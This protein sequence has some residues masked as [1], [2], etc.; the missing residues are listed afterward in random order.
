M[1]RAI[2]YINLQVMIF[3]DNSKGLFENYCKLKSKKKRMC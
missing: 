3:R 1:R 2:D